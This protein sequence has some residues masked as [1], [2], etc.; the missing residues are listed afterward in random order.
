MDGLSGY[1]EAQLLP[2]TGAAMRGISCSRCNVIAYQKFTDTLQD[3]V[4]APGP[5]NA[6]KIR[7]VAQIKKR[8]L[9]SLG[10]LGEGSLEIQDS[11]LAAEIIPTDTRKERVAIAEYGGVVPQAWAEALARLDP[12][13][14]PREVPPRCWLHFIDDCGRFLD[15][16][17]AIR[18]AA[19][20]WGLL[21]L[22][23]CDRKRPMSRVDHLGLVWLLNGGTVVELQRDGAILETP[24]GGLQSYPRRPIE[25]GL[26][27]LPWELI[28]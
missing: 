27:V 9:G 13:K 4:D 6:P 10:T 3:R 24:G 26:I 15:G 19:L 20:G 2:D 22:F 16:G 23:G 21:D 8:T 5:P 11:D 28:Q 17:W 25:V 1:R 18:A 7:P 14:P 12:N